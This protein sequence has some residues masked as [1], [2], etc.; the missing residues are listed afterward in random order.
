MVKDLLNGINDWRNVEDIVRITFKALS[1]VVTAQANSIRELERQLPYKASKQELTS[2]L[3]LKV[4]S[5]DI[6]RTI[7]EI[8]EQVD[9]K[10]DMNDI[11]GILDERVTRD[12]FK[13]EINHILH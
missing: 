5:T 2:A 11:R 6:S 3:T 13:H 12:E 4:N 7:T 1:D 10:V 9:R 8:V